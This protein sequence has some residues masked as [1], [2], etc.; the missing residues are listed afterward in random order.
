MDQVRE[1]LDWN[2][3]DEI[4]LALGGQ[5]A[6]KEKYLDAESWF[7]RMWKQAKRLDLQRLPPQRILD[8]GT[9]PGH[10][11]YVCAALGHDAWGLDRPGTAAYEALTAWMGV[12]VVPH[13]IRAQVPLP[14][15][16]ARFDLVT[17]FRIG[18]NSKGHQGRFIL[19]DLDDWGFFLDDLRD[20]V[21]MPQGRVALKM[22][23]AQGDYSGLKFGDPPLMDY[24]ESRGAVID[25][26]DCFIRFDVLR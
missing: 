15:F 11:P 18:F 5:T 7:L 4:R 14:T 21:L 23:G 2:R 26:E 16:P 1:E 3:Y 25:R 12:R 17:A 19:F 8:L 9:G 10:F 20:N 6:N 13:K 22:T 24:F